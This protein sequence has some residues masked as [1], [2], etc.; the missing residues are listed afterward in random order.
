MMSH[1]LAAVLLAVPATATASETARTTPFRL[2]VPGVT[3]VGTYDQTR[4]TVT[5]E[6]TGRRTCGVLQ[7]RT[8]GEWD[9]AAALCKPGTAAIGTEIARPPSIRLCNGDSLALAEGVDCD[10]VTT[11]A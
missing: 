6:V 8:G 4:L 7:L 1:V 2:A 10:R 9:T 11:G 5:V 3:A